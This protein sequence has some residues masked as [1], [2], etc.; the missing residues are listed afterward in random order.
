MSL[1]VRPERSWARRSIAAAALAA[2][3]GLGCKAEAPAKIGS[4]APAARP[5][6]APPPRIP[7]L[8]WDARTDYVYRLEL[9]SRMDVG[10]EGA[11][12]DF[13]LAAELRLQPYQV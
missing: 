2:C 4:N 3:L 10:A 9:A 8:A 12:V 11:R 6:P 13:S 7:A 1:T 5:A